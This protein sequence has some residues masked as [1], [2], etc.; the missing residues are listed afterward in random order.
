M[1][2]GNVLVLGRAR[3]DLNQAADLGLV[4]ERHAEQF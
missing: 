1:S 4:V 2:D 3:D